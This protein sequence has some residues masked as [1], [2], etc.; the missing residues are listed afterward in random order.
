MGERCFSTYGFEYEPGVDGYISWVSDG[1]VSWSMKGNAVP[2]NAA[3]Q[4]SQRV[5]SQEPMV[6]PVS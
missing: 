3:A 5:I 6:R 2:A 1:K 4:I